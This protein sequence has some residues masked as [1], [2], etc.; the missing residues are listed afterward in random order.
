MDVFELQLELQLEGVES[1]ILDELRVTDPDA[2]S[3]GQT[4]PAGD[5]A[6][7]RGKVV[8]VVRPVPGR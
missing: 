4:M 6:T 1:K 8:A 3:R 5:K 2:P 7:I